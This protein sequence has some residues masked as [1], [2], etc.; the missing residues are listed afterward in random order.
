MILILHRIPAN[1]QKYDII[2]H[3]SPVLD[4]SFFKQSGHIEN[5]EFLI[6]EDT[7][8]NCLEYHALVAIDSEAAAKRVIK[9]LNRKRFKNKNIAIREYI[10]RSWH[11]D[12]RNTLHEQNEEF[13]NRRVKNRRGNRLKLLKGN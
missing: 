12:R 1:T 11:K 2:D 5:I 4:G 9:Q 8:K 10:I 3:L 13:I 7:H 6:F